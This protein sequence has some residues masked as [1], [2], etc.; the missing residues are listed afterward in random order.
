[1]SDDELE[2]FR[3]AGKIAAKIREESKRLIM[4]GE[5]LL[6]IA[7]M[8][9]Q[10]IKDEGGKPAFPVNIS[11]NEIA[12][13]YTPEFDSERLME[14]DALVKID[15]GI[16][17]DGAL[18][19]TAY[20]I[21]MSGKNE[22]LVKASEEAL[23]NAIDAIKPDVG[24]GEIG[25]LIEE[26]INK[27][28]FKPISNLS[29]H[30]IKSNQ[31]HAG[32]EIPNIRTKDIYKL[33]EGDIFAVEPFATTG[34]GYVEDLE[35]VEIFSL[36]SPANVRMR[37]S[38][39]IVDYVIKNY[40]MLPFA[41]RWVRKE[42]PSKLLVSAALKELLQNQFIRGY[43]VL[44]EVSRGLVSQAEHTILVTKDGCEVLTK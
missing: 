41:E 5:S 14:D 10:S 30:M 1:M 25:G 22:T 33:K 23:Q 24:V 27:Y 3:T 34:S 18:S 16:E 8:I 40:G 29:G 6:D 42:F 37:Q 38:R 7:D 19:D 20:T 13:H 11:I 4:V 21:D 32:V 43:P 36:Y 2:K 28:G 17:I 26:T 39:K 15:L 35:Q 44:R 9:E 31:L 12:A